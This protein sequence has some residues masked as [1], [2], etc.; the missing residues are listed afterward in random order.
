MWHLFLFY[1]QFCGLIKSIAPCGQ[2]RPSP[3][4]TMMHFPSLFQISPYFWKIFGLWRKCSQFDFFPENFLI[5]IRLNF[6]W[7]FFSHRPQ[8]SNFPPI[9]PVSVHFP[10][11]LQKLLSAPTF[12]NFPTVLEKFT[13]FLHTLCVFRFPPYFDRDAFMHRPMH[14]LDTP[15]WQCQPVISF[16]NGGR[17]R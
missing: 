11:V 9:I 2:G 4:E 10:P 13:S 5:F 3:P 16:D 6:W 12:N 17:W 8:I 15:V 7:L 14:V 1:F